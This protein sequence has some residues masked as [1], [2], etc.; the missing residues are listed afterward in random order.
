M[1]KNN[2]FRV[3]PDCSRRKLILVPQG[4]LCNRLRLV[5][6]AFGALKNGVAPIEIHWARNAECRAWFE[7]LFLPVDSE[8]LRIVHRSLWAMP[9][10]LRNLHLPAVL[11]RLM[12]YDLQRADCRPADDAEFYRMANAGKVFMSGGTTLC[13]Y[14]AE[15]LQALRPQPAIQRCIDEVT[16]GFSDNTIGVH[17][18][19]TDN[20]V[21]MRHST[22]DGFRRAMDRAVKSDGNTRFFLA[23]D[24]HLLKEKMEREY[25]TRIIT[26][27]VSVSRDTVDGMRNAVIDLWCLAATRRIIGSYWSSFTDTAAELRDIPLEVVM[28]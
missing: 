14:D 2:T 13:S 1:T 16:A 7:D 21:S 6:S 18:R 5:L 26:R 17:I 24:D 20:V 15:C 4:G 12:G 3:S 8:A 11:R 25:G 10:T 27:H 19:R 9:V 23:T 28:D 22:P